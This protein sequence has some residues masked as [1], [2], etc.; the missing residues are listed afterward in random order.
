MLSTNPSRVW[1]AS[2]T[3]CGSVA[4]RG[5]G[6]FWS[7]QGKAWGPWGGVGWLL[8]GWLLRP[9]MS[10]GRRPRRERCSPMA[11]RG[12]AASPASMA[13]QDALVLL[14]GGELAVGHDVEGLGLVGQ[15]V[16][17]VGHDAFED[18]VP[19]ARAIAAWKLE[20]RLT[21]TSGSSSAAHRGHDVPEASPVPRAMR[22]SAAS[23]AA[24]TSMWGRA[25]VRSRAEYWPR[26]RS[27]ATWLA[28]HE[29]ALAGFGDGQAQGGAGAQGLADH[30]AAH[31]V[32]LR[33]RGL[34]A[35]L[36]AD[37]ELAGFD[38]R[39]EGVEDGFGGAEA[40]EGQV[41]RLS[42]CPAV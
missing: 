1:A 38:F 40:G 9:R 41:R 10:R 20:S 42:C 23:P 30:R 22:R 25:S 8:A 34:G 12:G 2:G 16:A 29:R 35:Q 26:T 32:L 19:L 7:G 15:G 31:A 5:S 36:G 14:V 24:G 27:L 4:L 33:E 17:D 11:V 13:W 6:W 18:L 3:C 28:T 39:A 21:H 37:A